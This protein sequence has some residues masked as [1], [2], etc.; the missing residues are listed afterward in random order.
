MLG[1]CCLGTSVAEVHVGE[2]SF[3]GV[4]LRPFFWEL[5]FGI[6]RFG[7]FASDAPLGDFFLV[8]IASK[9][10]LGAP[11]LGDFRLGTFVLDPWL[12]GVHLGPFYC[13]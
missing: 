6:L 9:L 11:S 8:A 4:R 10:A 1:I 12:K 2:L 5:S 7:T 13:D 3:D